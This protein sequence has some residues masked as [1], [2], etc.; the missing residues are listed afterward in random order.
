MHQYT[1]CGDSILEP[2]VVNWTTN[3]WRHP[4]SPI[5]PTGILL[6]LVLE[7]FLSSSVAICIL[8]WPLQA[9][10]WL[11]GQKNKKSKKITI[12]DFPVKY[13]VSFVRHSEVW[14]SPSENRSFFVFCQNSNF[15]TCRGYRQMH[16]AWLCMASTGK[17]RKSVQYLLPV[18][19]S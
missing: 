2:P 10:E 12:S 16:K 18:K 14:W 4:P 9:S 6:H 7:F 15:E 1:V 8:L 5:N 17:G 19:W 11:F 3:T 13:V